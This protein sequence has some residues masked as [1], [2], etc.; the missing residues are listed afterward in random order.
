MKFVSVPVEQQL[1]HIKRH[2]VVEL[3][4]EDELLKKLE[5]AQK[6]GRPLRIKYGAD[7]SRPDLHLGHYVCFRKLKQFQDLDHKVVFIIGDFTAMIGDPSGRS[8]TR[9]RLTEEEVRENAK[10]YMEQVGKVL[11]VERVEVV[12]NSKWLG[13]LTAK[14]VIELAATYT[15]ARMLE[16]DDFAH[17]FKS[18]LPLFIHELL[19]PLFQGYDSYM[20]Q[21]DVEIGGTDQKFNF[22]VGREVQRAF[23]QEPQVILTLPLLEGTDGKRKMSKSFGNYI[24]INDPPNEIYGKV[25]SIPD[26]LILR[27][28]QLV[29]YYDE[30]ELRE[31]EKQMKENPRDAKAKLAY[32]IVKLFYPESE[33]KRAE[34]EFNRIFREKRAPSEMPEFRI[35]QDGKWIVELIADIGFAKSRSEARRLIAQGGV[36]VDGEPVR[37]INFVVK[38]KPEGVVLKVG[39]RKFAKIK[40]I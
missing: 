27:Y 25:M 20:I 40:P 17:R 28:Y 36:K 18:G 15:V 5:R 4:S 13:R 39:K 22:V 34:E 21:A 31:V 1:E 26:E 11:D 24:A 35:P 3:I 23:G 38:P 33:A 29:L 14:E 16:R 32:E 37:D 8:K 6:M 9:P 10:T 19:Y 7:P 2:N 30:D 12:F